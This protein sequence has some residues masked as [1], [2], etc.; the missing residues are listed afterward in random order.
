MAMPD[1]KPAPTTEA[2]LQEFGSRLAKLLEDFSMNCDRLQ[3][4]IDRAYGPSPEAG[5]VG[6]PRAVPSG[7]IGTVRDRLEDLS[8]VAS[9]QSSL[10]NRLDTVV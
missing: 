1:L 2:A 10:L 9:A 7:A 4:A 8:A 3:R 6:Q 5:S